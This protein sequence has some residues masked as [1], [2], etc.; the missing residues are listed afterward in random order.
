M[1]VHRPDVEVTANGNGVTTSGENE[2]DW[3]SA[4]GNRQLATGTLGDKKKEKKAV[5]LGAL[6]QAKEQYRAT[7]GTVRDAVLA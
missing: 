5:K 3:F 2:C 1:L 7:V 6:K 4:V